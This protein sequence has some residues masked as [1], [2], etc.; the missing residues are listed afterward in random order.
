MWLSFRNLPHGILDIAF[1][2]T[3]LFP[4][5]ASQQTPDEIDF[6][7]ATGYADLRVCAQCPL[8]LALTGC[9]YQG[10]GY[11]PWATGCKTNACLCRPG[12]LSK[13]VE[14]YAKVVLEKCEDADEVDVATSFLRSYCV[15][16][17]YATGEAISGTG[18]S[19]ATV[20]VTVT[21]TAIPTVVS[22]A[23]GPPQLNLKFW[24]MGGWTV[25]AV[26]AS[27]LS[28]SVFGK[29]RLM[30]NGGISQ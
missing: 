12:T 4:Q 20:T 1:C 13:A 22:A 14:G 27:G 15:G 30:R 24:P 21:V 17:G 18:A 26:L 25:I 29:R 6:V 11:I 2:I 5:T 16:K 8:N 3:T 7:L 10:G 19:L 9:P 28:L 23:S